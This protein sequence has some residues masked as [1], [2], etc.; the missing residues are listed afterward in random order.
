M[1]IITPVVKCLFMIVFF[2]LIVDCTSTCG[3][4][5][6]KVTKHNANQIEVISFASKIDM[7]LIEC[8]LGDFVQVA[9]MVLRI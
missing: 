3:W 2:N 1:G 4:Y 6:D 7:L 9:L 8:I 5:T